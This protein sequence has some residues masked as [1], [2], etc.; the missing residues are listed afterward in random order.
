MSLGYLASSLRVQVFLRGLEP[1]LGLGLLVEQ[2]GVVLQ[3]LAFIGVVGVLADFLEPGLHRLGGDLLLV[4]L[5]LDDLG[6]QSFL[7]AVLLA[8]L[9][10]L[11]LQRGEL[12][13]EWLRWRPA[14]RRS[15][16]R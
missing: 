9:V 15:S 11:L 6:E 4:A 13:F 7:A 3:R 2:S 12:A 10:E 8:H 1:S 14:R 16:G 5:A